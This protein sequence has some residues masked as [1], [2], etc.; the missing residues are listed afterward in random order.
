ML[1]ESGF[2]QTIALRQTHLQHKASSA[3]FVP[4]ASIL[5]LHGERWL[6]RCDDAVTLLGAAGGGFGVANTTTLSFGARRYLL[7]R[8]GARRRAGDRR[9]RRCIPPWTSTGRARAV[10]DV[11]DALACGRFGVEWILHAMFNGADL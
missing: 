6:L 2:A 11:R 1:S 8:T 9:P 10:R 4:T 3:R 5:L 7:V